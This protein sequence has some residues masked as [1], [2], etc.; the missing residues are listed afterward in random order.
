MN[1]IIAMI[2]AALMVVSC[3]KPEEKKAEPEPQKIEQAAPQPAPAPYQD[4]PF[5]HPDPK[6]PALVAHEVAN[7]HWV[8]VGDESKLNES[9][10]IFLWRDTANHNICYFYNVFNGKEHAA[11]TGHGMSCVK[12]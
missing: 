5:I 6:A 1:K 7:S 9:W 12:E 2:A 4:N 3:D 8:E 10:S 11:V